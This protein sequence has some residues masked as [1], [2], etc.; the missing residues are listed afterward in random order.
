LSG[1]QKQRVALARAVY[2]GKAVVILDDPFSGL[3]V[4]TEEHIFSHVF[5]KQGL[6]RKMGTTVLLVSHAVHRLSYA[7]HIIALDAGGSIAE[8]GTYD[9][10]QKAGGYVA[11]LETR[12]CSDDGSK[13]DGEAGAQEDP[14]AE[15]AALLT[16][17]SAESSAL[18]ETNQDLLRQNGDLSLYLYYFGAVHWASTALWVSL[19]VFASVAVKSSE[20]LVNIWT[21]EAQRHGNSVN[22]FYMGIYGSLAFVGTAGLFAGA[23]HFILYFSP[24]GAIVLHKR[25]L[26]SVMNSPLSFFTSVDTGTTTNR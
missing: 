1:G 18:E 6:F 17:L 4:G 5:S 9:Q 7:D 13:L 19:L 20:Y 25:L 2:S 10:L 21:E 22:G 14:H 12:R 24:K 16:E 11:M 15:P 3:D 8:Q 26:Q 23:Y